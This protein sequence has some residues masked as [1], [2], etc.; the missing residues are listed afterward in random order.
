MDFDTRYGKLN[1]A[2][3]QAVDTIDGPLLVIAGPGTG[4][5]ELLSM[6]AANILRRTDTLAE[7]ILCL[8]F[9]ESGATAMRRRLAEIIGADAYRVAIHT[10][11][12]FGTEIIN[13]E[14]EYFYHGASFAPA[15][16]LASYQVL[17]QIFETLDYT[18]P[19]AAQMNGEFV[20]LR[21]TLHTI[22]ELKRSGLTSEELR[23][24][25]DANDMVLDDIE[26]PL[27]EIFASRITKSTAAALLP[28]ST[29]IAGIASPTLPRG[30]TPMSHL[31]SLE[32]ARAL[33]EAAASNSTRPITAWKNS[34]LARDHDGKLVFKDRARHHKLRAL[35]GIYSQ[36]LDR[37]RAAALYDYD[38]MILE[39]VHAL[40][41]RP[42]L[43]YDLQERYQYIMV[44]EFQDT[45]LAQLRMLFALTD[46]ALTE[47]RPNVMAVGDDDQAIY[48]F[49]GADVT[50]IYK[51]RTA[52]RE[53]QLI[54][55][56]DNYRSLAPI[57]AESRAVI[58]QSPLPIVGSL[59]A[60]DKSLVAHRGT[61]RRTTS[62]VS[63]HHLSDQAAERQWLA[64]TIASDIA[65]GAAPADIAVLGRRHSDLVALLPYLVAAGIRVSY[66]R[67]DNILELPMIRL[68]LL[69]SQ[70]VIE[71]ADG[72]H[73]TADAMLPELL[74]HPALG[75][76]SALI[77]RLSLRAYRDR[78][79][80]MEILETT[81]ELASLHAWLID[82]ARRVDSDPLE[83]LID[84]M[85]GTIDE[86]SHGYQSP[87]YHYYFAPERLQTEP[88]SYIRC[89]DALST[90]RRHLEAYRPH[91]IPRLADLIEFVQLHQRLGTSLTTTTAPDEQATDAIHLMTAHKSK[92]LEFD[93]VY[94]VGATDNIWGERVRTKAHII[95]YPHNLREIATSSDSYD[96][97]LR[98]FYV[99]MTRAKSRLMI[100]YADIDDAGRS[101][102]P[103]A[104]LAGT[105]LAPIDQPAPS[106]I[107][108]RTDAALA[109]WQ[110]PLI[111]P[112]TSDMRQL[113]A[114]LL[115]QYKLSATHLTNFLDLSYGG[116]QHFLLNNLLRF[117]QAKSPLASYGTA[118]HAALQRAHTHLAATGTRRPVED[119]LGD[120][121][122][123]LDEQYLTSDEHDKLLRRGTDALSAF[124]EARYDTFAPTQRTELSFA[125][126]GAILGE[127]RLTGSL[128]LVDIT[129]GH[130][131]VTDYKTGTPSS[132]WTGRTE[133]ER[134]KLH[135]YRQQLMFYQ[136]LVAHS[137]EYRRYIFGGAVLQFVEPS[138]RGNICT[139]D[140]E[141]TEAELAEFSQLI[142]AV[143][144][145]IMALD[146]PDTSGYDATYQGIRQF[147]QDLLDGKV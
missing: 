131:R 56:T 145:H 73:D 52:Y 98:L 55:L 116:P 106:T 140:A 40:E 83:R 117:P 129:D 88:D 123:S 14:R 67:R 1:T 93:T 143:W 97:R 30:I 132:S 95:S 17:R 113:I 48:S 74:A 77:W 12:S 108:A 82:L 7:S 50:N 135:K 3:R 85:I 19:L 36:Y 89:L 70:I 29:H 63:L 119:V 86:P 92:G 102:L 94:I 20:H 59:T 21:D 141:F 118:V 47:G 99:A 16:E 53:P 138:P 75:L 80:W 133:Y 33:D 32:L 109:T 100:S 134:I 22:S 10:F 62:T 34:W 44:D 76:D 96:D 57:L 121:H 90:L 126:Q 115:Q 72:N 64:S 51:F 2:Q 46:N 18:S 9:T 144:Q 122:N 137:R 130:I 127:A 25:L 142:Q 139:L 24:I 101:T 65:A 103:A 125:G 4:K 35:A 15:D 114:P 45:N 105:S 5:T 31:L 60:V 124:L 38:D 26:A 66:E 13:R 69:L 27:A 42:A 39:V 146:L 87:L 68:I 84:D 54:T 128:D 41:Q 8:T 11:H 78:C 23:H 120:F 71:L 81:P 79:L 61:G 37:L 58:S 110:A 6:R 28:L 147:E 91:A 43:R 136:L 104:F 107:A 49:Q 112:I 111:A